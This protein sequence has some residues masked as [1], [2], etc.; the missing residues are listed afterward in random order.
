MR[1]WHEVR[2]FQVA[3]VE[4]QSNSTPDRYIVEPFF[5]SSSMNWI[6]SRY[7]EQ[8][9]AGHSDH[10]TVVLPFIRA[11]KSSST[12]A[13]SP[14]E[15]IY[16][17][18]RPT[19]GNQM[20]GTE[21]FDAEDDEQVINTQKPL[22]LSS[23][24]LI[25]GSPPHPPAHVLPRSSSPGLRSTCISYGSWTDNEHNHQLSSSESP[26]DHDRPQIAVDHDGSGTERVLEKDFQE[27]GRPH[28]RVTDALMVPTICVG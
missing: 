14:T 22:Q 26:R 13:P 15:G 12:R 8:Y 17:W 5:F 7:Q 27:V 18:V 23:S 6:S 25:S 21:E 24:E 4:L 28:I 1:T 16:A 20:Y 3:F 11:I 10:I 9:R 19:P 2:A